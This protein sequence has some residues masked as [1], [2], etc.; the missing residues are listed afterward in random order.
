MEESEAYKMMDYLMK[1]LKRVVRRKVYSI[2]ARGGI[3]NDNLQQSI[4]FV[5]SEYTVDI[6][7]EI[8]I[9]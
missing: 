2:I 3:P 9:Y 4:S 5:V 6:D 8:D 1:E 7:L